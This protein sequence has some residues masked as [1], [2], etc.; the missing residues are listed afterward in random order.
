MNSG[1]C[2][3]G[4]ST[5]ATRTAGTNGTSHSKGWCR[6][7][8]KRLATDL[9]DTQR[10]RFG[11]AESANRPPYNRAADRRSFAAATIAEIFAAATPSEFI[12]RFEN[13]PNPQS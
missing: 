2:A 11:Y 1:V 5:S 9:Q 6:N 10:R 8:I 13:V 7:L 4:A 12:G 3:S